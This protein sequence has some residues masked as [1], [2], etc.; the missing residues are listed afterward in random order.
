ME[1]LLRSGK[2]TNSASHDAAVPP[3]GEWPFGN[4]TPRDYGV[5]VAD[6][7][8]EFRTYNDKGHLKSP[9][10]HYDCLSLDDIKA[11]PVDK[12]ARSDALLLLWTTGWAMA[13][14]AAQEVARS[15]GATPVSEMVWR[16]ITEKNGVLRWG[17]GYRVR[18]THEPILVATWGKPEFK[19]MPSCIDG[20]AREHSRKPDEV[21]E[22]I[23]KNTHR[24]LWRCDLFSAGTQ[25]HGFEGWGQDH[26]RK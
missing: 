13:T 9:Q 7:P 20:I 22:V 23:R 25:H 16:K 6:P 5:I 1:L 24:L 26:R 8:W 11:L 15:W 14:G 2:S 21:Y 12:L 4:L 18:T 10:H 3:F 17:P 19:A